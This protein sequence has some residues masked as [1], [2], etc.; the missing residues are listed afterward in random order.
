MT[1]RHT[2]HAKRLAAPKK[3]PLLRKENKYTVKMQPGQHGREGGVPLLLIIRDHLKHVRNQR[4]ARGILNAGKVLVD[5]KVRKNLKMPVGLMDVISVPETK[6]SL[7]VIFDRKGRIKL[8]KVN[9]AES[10]LKLCKVLNKTA[11]KNNKIQL[12]LHDG[13]NLIVEA[14]AYKT[15]DSVLISLPSQEIKKHVVIEKGAKVYV[16][17]GTH[18]GELAVLEDFKPQPGSQSDR[19]VLKGEDGETFETLKKYV[20]IIGKEKPE[21]AIEGEK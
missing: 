6:E 10:K 20:F 2:G 4:E 13:R 11:I 21:I 9:D 5:G 1:K 15:G 16:M 7:R 18:I 19:V 8:I 12:N 3:Y 17:D 14:G